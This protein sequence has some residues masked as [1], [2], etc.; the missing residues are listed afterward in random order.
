MPVKQHNVQLQNQHETQLQDTFAKQQNA[1]TLQK[2]KIQTKF[3]PFSRI[4]VQT[5][6][7]V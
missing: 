4:N 3:F 7:A 1:V 6:S 2:R 5:D